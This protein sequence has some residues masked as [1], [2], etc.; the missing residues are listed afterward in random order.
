MGK[1]GTEPHQVMGK[2]RQ[3]ALWSESRP[4]PLGC[5]VAALKYSTAFPVI[6]LSAMKYHVSPAQWFGFYHPLWL[7]VS[8]LNSLFSFAWDV[9]VDWDLL[10]CPARYPGLRD[11]LLY[12]PHARRGLLLYYWCAFCCSQSVCRIPGA[13]RRAAVHAARPPWAAPLL[14]VRLLLFTVRV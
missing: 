7:A 4:D 14:L 6:V 2:T 1:E 5:A 10:R 13:A 8:L 3:E 11:E 9:R 12:T